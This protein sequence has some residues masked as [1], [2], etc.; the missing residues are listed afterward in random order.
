[1]GE[2][3]RRGAAGRRSRE[4][5]SHCAIGLRIG[6][7]GVSTKPLAASRALLGPTCSSSVAT[8]ARPDGDGRW[9]ANFGGY[10]PPPPVH[11]AGTDQDD[12]GSRSQRAGQSR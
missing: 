8:R 5:P 1:M 11:V 10:Q 9:L 6:G 4:T 3:S 12:G 7:G 2:A